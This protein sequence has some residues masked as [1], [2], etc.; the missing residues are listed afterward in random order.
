MRTYLRDELAGKAG[1]G[2]RFFYTKKV[3]GAWIAELH[4]WTTRTMRQLRWTS[5]LVTLAALSGEK[6]RFLQNYNSIKNIGVRVT[7][8][9]QSHAKNNFKKWKVLHAPST[10]ILAK[11]STSSKNLLIVLHNFNS[12]T[13]TWMLERDELLQKFFHH[14][15]NSGFCRNTL[16]LALSWRSGELPVAS[17]TLDKKMVISVSL[18][19]RPYFNSALPLVCFFVRS[20]RN[21]FTYASFT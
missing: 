5:H 2:E 17:T 15:E 14:S 21:S 13:S 20:A 12:K 7:D 11:V 4:N 18:Q 8:N 1:D 3:V 16:L 19:N 10:V 9:R 6:V